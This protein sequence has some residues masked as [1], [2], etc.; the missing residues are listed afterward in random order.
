MNQFEY[1]NKYYGLNLT[2][3]CPVESRGKHGQ[4]VKSNRS[5][6]FIQWDG[7]NKPMGPYHPTS[8]LVYP[9]IKT[10]R[11]LTADKDGIKLN[12]EIIS[13]CEEANII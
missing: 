13:K 5:H 1:I 10:P 9:G 7:D 8:E 12:G 6:I 4:V 2:K 3:Y 11:K